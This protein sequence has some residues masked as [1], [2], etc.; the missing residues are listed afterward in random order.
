MRL[1]IGM[2][3]LTAL[4]V[5]LVLPN[6]AIAQ[7]TAQLESRLGRLESDIYQVRSELSRLESQ[8]YNLGRSGSSTVAPPQSAPRY[9][10]NFPRSS[11]SQPAMFD[12][13]ATLAIELKERITSL[14]SRV[15]RLE[16]SGAKRA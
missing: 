1:W 9:E 12:R 8:I 15:T 5:G 2:F 13:L 4:I 14:E 6:R 16:K 7:S 10:P 11:P 3:C